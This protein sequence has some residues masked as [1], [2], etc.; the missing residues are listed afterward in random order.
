M[1]NKLAKPQLDVEKI[2]RENLLA[3][4]KESDRRELCHL[5]P[6]RWCEM[7]V[8]LMNGSSALEIRKKLGRSHYTV[9]RVEAQMS[10]ELGEVA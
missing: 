1:E 3:T 5:D 9:K 8:M 7:A 4:Q 6:E 2:V 10:Q